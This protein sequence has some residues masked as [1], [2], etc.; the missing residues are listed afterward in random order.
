MNTNEYESF[1]LIL[2]AYFSHVAIRGYSCSFVAEIL[3]C[4]NL[5]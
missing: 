3:Y 1:F 5:G 4:L 2:M